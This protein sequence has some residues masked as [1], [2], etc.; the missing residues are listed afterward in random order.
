[1]W[2]KLSLQWKVLV[3]IIG[4]LF[5][6]GLTVAVVSQMIVTEQVK[7]MAREKAQSD[8]NTL[9]ELVDRELPG[10]WR[11]EDAVLYKGTQPI[12]DNNSLVD[13][14]GELTGNTVTIF[15]GDTRVATNVMIEGRR[16]VGTQV[17]GDVSQEVLVRGREYLGE[18][19]V[20]GVAYQTA[21]KPIR[22]ADGTTIGMFYT[23]A[24][25]A[26]IDDVIAAFNQGLLTVS[27][28]A[29]VILSLL[30]LL[31]TKYSITNP[32]SNVSNILRRIAD[33]DLHVDEQSSAVTYLK[34]SDEIGTMTRALADMQKSLI[35]MVTS[36][37][38]VA[39]NVAGTSENLAA[40][41]QENSATI[42]EVASS[43][44]TFS[45]SVAD[46]QRRSDDMQQDAQTIGKL[47]NESGGKMEY[48][49]QSMDSIVAATGE[50]KVTLN[51]LASQA[52]N[53]E[54]ILE[55]ISAVADQ[56][57]LLALNAAIE[58]ARAGEHGRGFAVVADE[59]RN[60]AEQTQRSVDDI[61]K[62]VGTLVVS[63]KDSV[64]TM[65][66]AETHTQAGSEQLA[67]TQ[68]SFA[69]ISSRINNTITQI[70]MIAQSIHSMA[71]ASDSIAAASEEQAASMQEVAGT[72][73]TLASM[74][75]QL[76][77]VVE[78]FRL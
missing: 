46:A 29:I 4:G 43:A 64:Q 61:S 10:P 14:L 31:V 56:T 32:I 40:S 77:G 65:N 19:I 45:Q 53:M 41:A 75:E 51:D 74:S 39:Q 58:A 11:I 66:E 1:M 28:F 2:N 34:R 3:P 21:Y 7:L 27:V 37:Q 35:D 23:G 78:R 16:A 6:F 12:N 62:M 30:L 15:R 17:A 60:L 36:L 38:E 70:E 33:L 54:K 72:T 9:Y 44:A 71:E 59:V 20:V 8:L 76:A 68:E 55:M 25:Q 13:W 22:A 52:Q 48:T 50:V 42:E 63:A 67:S 69:D 26:L 57:N 5:L 24:S 73:Q 18:A 49:R 47:S